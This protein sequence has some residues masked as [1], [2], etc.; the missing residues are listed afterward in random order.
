MES[1]LYYNDQIFLIHILQQS[2]L[3][4]TNQF[5]IA[6]NHLD[7]RIFYLS[8]AIL[9][10][11]F[12]TAFYARR[13][14]WLIFLTIYFTNLLKI[15]FD[16]PRP[17]VLDPSVALVKTTS[18]CG[19]PSGGAAAALIIC[20]F[21]LSLRPIK[22][23]RLLALGYVAIASF[24]RVYIGMHFFSDIIAGWILAC[25]LFAARIY[26]EKLVERFLP[27]KLIIGLLTIAFSLALYALSP[28]GPSINILA[29]G[30]GF[31]ISTIVA[32]NN[33]LLDPSQSIEVNWAKICLGIA[34]FLLAFLLPVISSHILV[35]FI[36]AL[37]GFLARY[38]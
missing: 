4:H 24:C 9:S 6:L 30:T 14:W 10:S 13:I 38:T 37:M 19:F 17:L 15:I 35:F 20:L 25:C 7:S 12:F 28:T 16:L 26:C 1:L 21:V 34:L 3:S 11:I 29:L 5:W 27:S 32:R 2:V 31:G 8:V 33:K 18:L 22:S 36:Y 23:I